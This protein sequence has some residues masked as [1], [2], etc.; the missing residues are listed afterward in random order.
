MARKKICIFTSIEGHLSIA[1]SIEQTLEK[2]FDVFTYCERDNL[3]NF[4]L[5]IY[6]FF[7]G[8]FKHPFKISQK[9]KIVE[10]AKKYLK[11]QYRKKI[12]HFFDLHQPDL[13]IT[14]YYMYNPIL[15]ELCAQH[16]VPFINLLADPRTIHPISFS[17]TADMNVVFDQKSIDFCKQFYPNAHYKSIGW[18]TK[19]QFYLPFDVG[20][21]REQLHLKKDILT[22]LLV[23]G[24]EGT[25]TITTILPSVIRSKKPLQLIIA[26]G[27][28]K[29]L[30]KSAKAFEVFLKRTKS[31]HKIIPLGYT[32]RLHEYMQSADLIIGKAGPNTLFEAVATQVPFFATM[33]IA[34]QEDG[35]LD[36]IHDYK[37]GYVEEN[38]FKAA[39]ELKKIIAQSAKLVEFKPSLKAL[40]E[41]NKA[42]KEEF[43]HLAKKYLYA[44]QNDKLP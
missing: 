28:N 20:S 22:L 10:M 40:A 1:Q 25:N 29:L 7:P 26:C 39:R 41:Y 5:P 19:D 27:G 4:Y 15:E 3:Y 8:A 9:E 12:T 24:S 32:H 13:C 30:Y 36:I 21:V 23:S 42:A 6:Q 37:L 34:G 11:S 17:E 18:M 38:P 31:R 2:E 35:N 33:H 14:T 44:D 43:L 16:H